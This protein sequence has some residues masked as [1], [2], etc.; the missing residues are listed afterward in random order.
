M[1]ISADHKRRKLLALLRNDLLIFLSLYRIPKALSEKAF[2]DI[3]TKQAAATSAKQAQIKGS[4]S[5][6]LLWLCMVLN[7]E[8]VSALV[9]VQKIFG[10]SL[11]ENQ[12]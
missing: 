3:K 1:I 9:I 4:Q 5:I 8:S 7:V 10:S 12:N 11:K 2:T 6:R